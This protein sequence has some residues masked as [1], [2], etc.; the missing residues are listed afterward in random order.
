MCVCAC[1][2]V[3]LCLCVRVCVCV[4]VCVRARARASVRVCVRCGGGGAHSPIGLLLRY[5]KLLIRLDMWA[6]EPLIF[7]EGG[8]IQ[9]EDW[10]GG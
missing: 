5:G 4:C 8:G 1:A 2:C 6:S 3:C 9:S 10:Y 7:E